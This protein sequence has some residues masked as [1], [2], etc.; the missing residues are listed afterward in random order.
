[1]EPLV[2]P[3]KKNYDEFSYFLSEISKK[4]KIINSS[5]DHTGQYIIIQCS[6]RM[7]FTFSV[8]DLKKDRGQTLY[9]RIMASIDMNRTDDAFDNIFEW[10]YDSHTYDLLMD[11][12]IIQKLVSTIEEKLKEIPSIRT[13]YLKSVAIRELGNSITKAYLMNISLEEVQKLV[14]EKFVE[15]IQKV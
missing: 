7:E 13:E 10:D 11:C 8:L 15:N 5:I 4:F 12:P 1:M 14:L 3:S 9:Y 2:H 6:N